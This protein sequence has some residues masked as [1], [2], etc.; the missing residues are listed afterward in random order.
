ML[1]VGPE[2]YTK[3]IGDIAKPTPICA[4]RWPFAKRPKGVRQRT[5]VRLQRIVFE[6]VTE[7]ADVLMDRAIEMGSERDL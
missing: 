4:L 5:Y 2:R 3:V 1:G 6:S 7:A